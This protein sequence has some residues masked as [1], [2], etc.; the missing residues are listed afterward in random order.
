MA[1]PDFIR[2]FV[3]DFIEGAAVSLLALTAAGDTESVL[4]TAAI[5]VGVAAVAAAR[6]NA[7]RF[8]AFLNDFLNTTP[9]A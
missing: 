3:R 6:R 5:A 7:G 1:I 8:I 4:K 2:Y 9:D